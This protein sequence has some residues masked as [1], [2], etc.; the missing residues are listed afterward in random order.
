MDADYHGKYPHAWAR[1]ITVSAVF[2]LRFASEL[3][4]DFNPEKCWVSYREVGENGK[5]EEILVV[6]LCSGSLGLYLNARD[7]WKRLLRGFESLNDDERR[8]A[9]TAA[10]LITY[11]AIGWVISEAFIKAFVQF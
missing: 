7:R 4:F 2:S 9:N 8:R 5:R 3:R 6:F 11:S 10:G 1:V